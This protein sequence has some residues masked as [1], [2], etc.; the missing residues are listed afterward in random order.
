MPSWLRSSPK[1]LPQARRH[2]VCVSPSRPWAV[3]EQRRHNKKG[4]GPGP[5]PV[6]T[7]FDLFQ[8]STTLVGGKRCAGRKAP[9]DPTALVRGRLDAQANVLELHVIV[10]AMV[11]AFAT[12]ARFFD[13]AKR[14][15]LS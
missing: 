2:N 12:Q 9:T 8:S 10:D 15:N 7:A 14:R 5:L 13:A 6:S 1:S 11:R 3:A 4:S